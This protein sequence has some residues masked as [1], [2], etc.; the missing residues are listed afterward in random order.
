MEIKGILV[1]R[2]QEF[3]ESLLKKT[4]EYTHPHLLT[5]DFRHWKLLEIPIHDFRNSSGHFC[6]AVPIPERIVKVTTTLLGQ[7]C[8]LT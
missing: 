1:L 5:P 2:V 4:A 8:H 6:H 7:N 3:R